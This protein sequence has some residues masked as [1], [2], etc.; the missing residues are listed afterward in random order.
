MQLGS[1]SC[2]HITFGKLLMFFH[3]LPVNSRS[4]TL[5]PPSLKTVLSYKTCSKLSY[6]I[7]ISQS[8]SRVF[9]KTYRAS[10]H[11]L[12]HRLINMRRDIETSFDT[13]IENTRHGLLPIPGCHEDCLICAVVQLL[14][15]WLLWWWDW[16]LG[17]RHRSHACR[18]VKLL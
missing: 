4:Q 5:E 14:W 13:G 17:L 2:G 6:H 3:M 8:C 11:P 1:L 16:C 18:L 9:S 7:V 15:L 12:P 10:P